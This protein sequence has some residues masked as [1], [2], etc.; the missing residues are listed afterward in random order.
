MRKLFVVMAACALL[1]AGCARPCGDTSLY[2]ISGRQ[3]PIVA[4]LP[5]IN[6]TSI[7]D[8]PWDLAREMTDE[9]R[10]RVYDSQKIYLLRDGG[11]LEVA[12]MLSVPNPQAISK[13]AIESL[14]EADYVI[15]TEMVEQEEKIFGNPSPTAGLLSMGLRVRVLDLREGTP[16]VILQEILDQ[17]Y[18]VAR[19][20]MNC[21]Y[22]K[23]SWGTEAYQH[24]PMGMAHGRL[25]HQL[26]VRAEAYIEATQ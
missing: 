9:I 26:V 1:C 3:K 12:K 25:I 24:T 4:V 16:K 13:E 8:L 19:A 15:V 23:M 7:D 22:H 14:A 2:Q 21:D 10:K 18:V 20:Y 11:S 17:D 5:V 6:H